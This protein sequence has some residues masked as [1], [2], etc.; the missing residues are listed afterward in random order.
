MASTVNITSESA[1]TNSQERKRQGLPDGAG[2]P[3]AEGRLF[4]GGKGGSKLLNRG[5][6]GLSNYSLR[7]EKTIVPTD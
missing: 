3:C 2:D 1:V 6:K 5:K 4:C 7:L